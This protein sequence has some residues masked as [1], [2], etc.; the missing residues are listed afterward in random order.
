MIYS[1][2]DKDESIKL[3]NWNKEIE[4]LE[5]FFSTAILPDR[6][7]NFDGNGYISNVRKFVDSHMSFV[8][9]QNGKK[10]FKPYLDR[11]ILLKNTLQNEIH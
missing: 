5:L 2:Y 1:L 4:S 11:L 7:D 8:V 6:L 3:D 9:A 10:Y